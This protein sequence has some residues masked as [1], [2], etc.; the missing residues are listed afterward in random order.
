ML[1]FGL[2]LKDKTVI[3]RTAFLMRFKRIILSRSKSVKIKL[4]ITTLLATTCLIGC[5]QESTTE[6]KDKETMTTSTPTLDT[7]ESKV[8]YLIGFNQVE[9][10]KTQGVELNFDAYLNGASQAKDGAESKFSHEEAQAIFTEFQTKMQVKMQE[11]AAK[12]GL[13]NKTQSEAFLAENKSKDGVTTTESG[14]QYKVLI[15]GNGSKPTTESTVQ[16]NY[17]G[18]L[19]DGTVFESSFERGTPVEFPLNGVIKGWTEGLQLMTEGSRF[20]FYIPTDLAY[21][22]N[23][24]PN[25]GPNQTLIFKI[26]LIQANFSAEK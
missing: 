26:E 9:Q 6:A 23:A 18:K 5:N 4:L 13:E 17:E 8:S 22:L 10:L 20:E 19:I 24:P 16:V 15:Q 14:L 7:L 12:A 11:E 3:I 2:N 25:I 21:G 1:R